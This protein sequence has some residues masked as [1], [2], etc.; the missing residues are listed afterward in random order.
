MMPVMMK[1]EESITEFSGLQLSPDFNLTR[2]I[3][4]HTH[5]AMLGAGA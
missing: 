1:C 3:Q 5:A 2:N 4:A